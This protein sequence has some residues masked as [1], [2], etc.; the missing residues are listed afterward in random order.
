MGANL[1]GVYLVAKM[2]VQ[3]LPEYL[4]YYKPDF[5]PADHDYSELIAYWKEKWRQIMICRHFRRLPPSFV[6]AEPE[7]T[8]S[9]RLARFY[10]KENKQ[11]S[12]KILVTMPLKHKF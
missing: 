12:A 8:K 6:T 9:G 2:F 3:L 5:H 1:F 4:A 7:S 11:N 10:D